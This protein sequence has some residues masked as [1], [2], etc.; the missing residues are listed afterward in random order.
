M[1]TEENDGELTAKEK[2]WL[3]VLGEA[4]KYSA[5]FDDVLKSI[6]PSRAG[7]KELHAKLE[8][9]EDPFKS[10]VLA[11]MLVLQPDAKLK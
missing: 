3:R 1:A 2:S 7:L 6:I 11:Y 9:I 4:R 10:A 8:E 5:R